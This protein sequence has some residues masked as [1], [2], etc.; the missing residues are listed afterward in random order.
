MNNVTNHE[1][2]MMYVNQS[3]SKLEKHFQKVGLD[4]KVFD[5]DGYDGAFYIVYEISMNDLKY[6]I[7]ISDIYQSHA[8]NLFRL[9]YYTF[10]DEKLIQDIDYFIQQCFIIPKL[11][12]FIVSPVLSF[13]GILKAE[14]DNKL[15]IQL[16]NYTLKIIEKWE[17]KML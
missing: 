14:F 10:T 15:V 2:M 6:T 17:V 1:N 3:L 5:K 4:Y 7:T 13:K 9:N 16:P 11:K 12:T 8:T